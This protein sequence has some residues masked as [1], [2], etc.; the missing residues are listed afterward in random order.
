MK[1]TIE[2]RTAS[3]YNLCF[4]EQQ[5][6]AAQMLMITSRRGSH[7]TGHS[8][9]SPSHQLAN[10]L[11][12]CR[13]HSMTNHRQTPSVKGI[14]TIP[15]AQNPSGQCLA[16]DAGSQRHRYLPIDTN[17]DLPQESCCF[18]DT[19]PDLSVAS[20]NTHCRARPTEPVWRTNVVL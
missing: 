10:D 6:T 20:P 19:V 13:L 5:L 15:P 3:R 7:S 1:S 12:I 4:V 17:C 18:P 9:H 11:T 14:F 16:A 2:Q 8:H